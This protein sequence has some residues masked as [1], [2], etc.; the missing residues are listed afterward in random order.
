MG[1]LR[2]GRVYLLL[3]GL[4]RDLALLTGEPEQHQQT[5][6]SED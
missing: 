2:R 6:T 1:T 5:K 4:P 3:E